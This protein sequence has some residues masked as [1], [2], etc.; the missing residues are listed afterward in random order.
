MLEELHYT[1]SYTIEEG[2][3]NLHMEDEY[4]NVVILNEEDFAFV[5]PVL[6]EIG[7][8]FSCYRDNTQIIL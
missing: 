4:D 3:P 8:Q 2:T 5:D 1:S 7:G 6:E